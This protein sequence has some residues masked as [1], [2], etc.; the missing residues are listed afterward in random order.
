MLR[1]IAFIMKDDF[2]KQFAKHVVPVTHFV[3]RLNILSYPFFNITLLTLTLLQSC[4][5]LCFFL[6]YS[7]DRTRILICWALHDHML[8]VLIRSEVTDDAVPVVKGGPSK[9]AV[10]KKA[11]TA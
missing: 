5:Y 7:I 8:G 9:P 3:M 4:M 6:F 10:F 2:A 11:N 1:I